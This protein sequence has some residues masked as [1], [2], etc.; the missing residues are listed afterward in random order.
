[1]NTGKDK[2]S[3]WGYIALFILS[4]ILIT[5]FWW[6]WTVYRVPEL[7]TELSVSDE[8][9]QVG[10]MFG[11]VAALFSGLAFA[12]I[13]VT[14]IMQGEELKLQRGELRLTRQELTKSAEA[15][16]QGALLNGHAALIQYHTTLRTALRQSGKSLKEVNHKLKVDADKISEIIG[17]MEGT[18]T[19]GTPQD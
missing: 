16:Q 2:K 5:V 19:T 9:G 3:V 6:Y 11:S 14:L 10:D 17:I 1:M 12:G 18:H 15:Q 8:M 13:I 7:A 4:G